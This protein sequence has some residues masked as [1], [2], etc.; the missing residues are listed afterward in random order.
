MTDL[1]PLMSS[2]DMGWQTPAEVLDLVRL[3]GP[4]VL[5]PCTT[6]DN[7]TDAC[8]FNTPDCC[9]LS[10]SWACVSSPGLV[11]VNPPYGRALV[12]WCAKIHSEAQAGRE[13][14]ALTPARTDTRWWHAH[15]SKAD[16]HCFWRGRMTFVGAPAGAPFP[17]VL[18]YFGERAKR[19]KTVFGPQ[20]WIP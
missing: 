16:A 18:S 5:D 14:I 8:V 17:S 3:V 10:T 11:Y 6:A 2:A 20:G 9:G 12:G 1:S 4:I 15:M 13:I 7:P 19:F